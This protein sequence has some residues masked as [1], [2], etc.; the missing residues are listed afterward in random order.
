[1]YET[2]VSL[3][4]LH[5]TVVNHSCNVPCSPLYVINKYKAFP[6]SNNFSLIWTKFTLFDGSGTS[7]RENFLNFEFFVS[8]SGA[9]EY[10]NEKRSAVLVPIPPEVP[11]QYVFPISNPKLA[12]DMSHLN[13]P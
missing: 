4:D 9:Y 8:L 5:I 1:M 10:Q 12:Q 3:T 13:D 2:L 6:Y 7:F 11:I